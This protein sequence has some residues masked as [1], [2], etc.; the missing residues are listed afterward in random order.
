MT[1]KNILVTGAAGFIGSCYAI[2]Q[3][4]EGHTVVA[5]D[6]CS[7]AANMDNLSAIREMAHFHFVKGDIADE[8]LTGKIL[9][10]Y[11]IDTV[12]HF[13]AESHVD[14]SISSPEIFFQTNVMGTF[15]LIFFAYQYWCE[16]NK[17]EDF[18]F[19]HVSTDEVFGELPLDTNDKFSE[20]SN[21][22]PNS[23]Y[24]ASKAGS[25]HIAR[26]W[27]H[28]YNMPVIITNCSNN[29]GPRQHK[30]KLIPHMINCALHEKPLPIYGS[31]E[32]VRD[33]I[34]VED[35]CSGIQLAV[36]KGMAG[37]SYCF[38]GNQEMT[39]INIVNLICEKLDDLKPRANG[40][41]YK[42]LMTFVEDRKGH[43][44]RYAIDD[45]KARKELGYSSKH[46][47]EENISQT[48]KWYLDHADRFA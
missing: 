41:S 47:F 15:H 36:E 18:R 9:R 4:Q 46:N 31:G 10:E 26:S 40:Q 29:Y 7:Y 2:Q 14:N 43:D 35:H 28:T 23:P 8:A 44:L 11:N 22:A 17:F 27:F 37:T 32:N 42:E 24:S 5:L 45:T 1:N 48:I 33:W 20:H 21:Y 30:E 3:V 19:I 39:N 13:A 6:N 38:G 25:D 12:V 16:K 34:Y